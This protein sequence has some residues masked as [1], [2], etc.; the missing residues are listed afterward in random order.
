MIEAQTHGI[1]LESIAITE[2]EAN[3]EKWKIC[4]GN[5]IMDW[6][7]NIRSTI[8]ERRER[9]NEKAR[10]INKNKVSFLA[11][12]STDMKWDWRCEAEHRRSLILF[13]INIMLYFNLT[14][15]SVCN[16]FIS[17]YTSKLLH[18]FDRKT[19]SRY[20]R[21]IEDINNRTFN[22]IWNQTNNHKN[23]K[24]E[25]KLRSLILIFLEADDCALWWLLVS[26]RFYDILIYMWHIFHAW[27]PHI[28][29]HPHHHHY[30]DTAR[31][32]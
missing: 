7:F 32:I 8:N 30:Y 2:H 17:L 6:K 10:K 4:D 19:D 21:R 18:D 26:L 3:M 23:R 12:I 1:V 14:F 5:V 16:I 29:L 27:I 9:T 31:T 13:D 24:D 25:L 15:S 22:F 11:V 28:H 20:G